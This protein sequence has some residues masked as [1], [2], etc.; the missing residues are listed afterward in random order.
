[1]TE[2]APIVLDIAGLSLTLTLAAFV[3]HAPW[4]TRLKTMGPYLALAL[5]LFVFS[6]VLIWNSQHDW[7]SFRFQGGRALGLTWP[8]PDYFL[9]GVGGMAASRSRESG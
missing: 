5:G 6:P 8:R 7:V 9:R 4:R 2:H 3:R 1:M